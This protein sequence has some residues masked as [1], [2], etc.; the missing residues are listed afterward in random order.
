MP[1]EG[2]SLA[3]LF[4]VSENG[5]KINELKLQHEELR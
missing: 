2:W 5:I 3:H 4:I 1:G